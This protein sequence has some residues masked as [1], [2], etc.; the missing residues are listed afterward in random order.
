MSVL[1][2]HLGQVAREAMEVVESP[3][4]T[5]A[6]PRVSVVVAS[7]KHRRFALELLA[8]LACQ[9]FRAFEVVV[10]D[11]GSNDGSFEALVERQSALAL[12]G[13]IVRLQQNRGRSVARNAGVRHARAELIAFTD[14]DCLPEPHWLERGL[15]PFR[16]PQVG[17]VQGRVGPAPDQRRP[18]FS[19][20]IDIPAFDGTYSTC[21]AFYR[22][23]AFEQVNGFDARVVYWEDVDLGYRTLRAGW[24]GAFA[25][26]AVVYH[27]VIPLTPVKWLKWPLL[28]RYMP[29]KAAAYPEYRRHLFLGVW[30]SWFHALVDLAAVGA[31]LGVLVH[32]AWLALAVPYAAAFVKQRGLRGRWFP[33]KVACHLLWDMF[34]MGVLAVSSVRHR[35]L[36]L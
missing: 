1:T 22:R 10:V 6:T 14:A 33:A 25:A 28:F 36:V 5:T 4:S 15:P 27:Q 13:R 2:G 23:D 34:S 12:P 11:D 30:V 35:S 20:F 16:D 21:N 3:A 29:A 17:V 9:T 19:H 26:D 18:F 31:V 24:R 8:A 7:Y 32:P